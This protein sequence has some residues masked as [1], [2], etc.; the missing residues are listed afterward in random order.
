MERPVNMDEIWGRVMGQHFNIEP[1]EEGGYRAVS[2]DGKFEGVGDTEGQATQKAQEK[3][4]E[5]WLNP[6]Q[7]PVETW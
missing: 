1:L 2:G 7:P 6:Q 4:I 5:F 3:L